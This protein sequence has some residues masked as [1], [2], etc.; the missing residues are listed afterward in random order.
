MWRCATL[1]YQLRRHQMT[2]THIEQSKLTFR[3]VELSHGNTT[4]KCVEIGLVHVTVPRV[5]SPAKKTI[6]GMRATLKLSQ[7]APRGSE[8]RQNFCMYPVSSQTE[9][10]GLKE[11][12]LCLSKSDID[13]M[14]YDPPC[15]CKRRGQFDV[16][17]SARPKKCFGICNRV[18]KSTPADAR[19]HGKSARSV[20]IHTSES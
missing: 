18:R 13:H 17:G 7:K 9:H 20:K 19:L 10:V 6:R 1:A 12:P 16:N 11:E 3:V 14:T 4:L 5:A 8:M 2:A 15:R